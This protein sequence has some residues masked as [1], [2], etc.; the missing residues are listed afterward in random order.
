M[1]SLSICSVRWEK[2]VF[3]SVSLCLSSNV[4]VYVLKGMCL[5]SQDTEATI[6]VVCVYDTSVCEPLWRRPRG[7]EFPNDTDVANSSYHMLKSFKQVDYHLTKQGL[8]WGGDSALRVLT[9][10]KL[11][12]V[13]ANS[14][15][16]S[17]EAF[18]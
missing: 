4:S 12:G 3:P 11:A 15:L 9:E 6:C 13:L 14:R 16:Q 1:Q 17:G 2:F 7:E 5:C 10:Y 18:G 8:Y